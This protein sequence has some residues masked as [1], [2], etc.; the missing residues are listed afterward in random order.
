MKDALVFLVD[1]YDDINTSSLDLLTLNKITCCIHIIAKIIFIRAVKEVQP[2]PDRGQRRQS[3]S[4]GPEAGWHML[5]LSQQFVERRRS[6]S[7]QMGN[8]LATQ[9]I[10]SLPDDDGYDKRWRQGKIH[11]RLRFSSCQ[12]QTRMIRSRFETNPRLPHSPAHCSVD[13]GN[14]RD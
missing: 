12:P 9:R 1:L 7:R 13:P 10:L 3:V 5:Y 11:L 8:K 14:P 6:I 2:L 4:P